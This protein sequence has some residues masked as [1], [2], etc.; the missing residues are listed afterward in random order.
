M[1]SGTHSSHSR[2][3][4]SLQKEILLLVYYCQLTNKSYN[5][6]VKYKKGEQK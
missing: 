2:K 5:S 4:Y 3:K 6:I 1:G